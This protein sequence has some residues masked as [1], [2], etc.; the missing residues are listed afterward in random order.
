M[1]VYNEHIVRL[2]EAYDENIVR[3][4]EAYL[5]GKLDEEG[6]REL[7]AWCEASEKNRKFFARIC[8]EDRIAREVPIYASAD[9]CRCGRSEGFPAFSET[10]QGAQ[11]VFKAS[12]TVC[13]HFVVAFGCC[14]SVAVDGSG[15]GSSGRAGDCS[16]FV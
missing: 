11:T 7:D 1:K 15:T 6:R 9:I 12:C 4:L 16:R 5:T 8:R 3:L 10:R 14:G 2:M 13:S